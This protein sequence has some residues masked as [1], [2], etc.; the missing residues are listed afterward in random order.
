MALVLTTI[1]IVSL[2][3]MQSLAWRGAGKS[4]YLGRAVGIIQG[5]LEQNELAIMTGNIP[6]DSK[7]CADK[8]GNEI[9]CDD[10][11]KMFAIDTA[12]VACL[13]T[14]PG[15]VVCPNTSASPSNSWRLDVRVSWPGS[16]KGMTSSVL[17]SRQPAF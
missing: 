4:D 10:A 5:V 2:L 13:G 15:S 7:T 3:S 11:G 14:A 17:I 9:A 6:A 12:T 8:D 1:T 16:A